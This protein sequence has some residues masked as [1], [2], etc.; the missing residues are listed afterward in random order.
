[1]KYFML[2]SIIVYSNNCTLLKN[3]PA[4][5]DWISSFFCKKKKNPRLSALALCNGPH[6]ICGLCFSLNLNKSISYLKK[7]KQKQPKVSTIFFKIDS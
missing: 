6:S 2:K 4:D 3:S 1:M 5:G 7:T